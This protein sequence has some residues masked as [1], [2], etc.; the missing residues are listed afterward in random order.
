MAVKCS[1][2]GSC[3]VFMP[4]IDLWAVETLQ[5]ETEK[6]DSSPSS[7]PL[8]KSN[9]SCLTH[10]QVIGKEI[11]SC[12][13]QHKSVETEEFRVPSHAWSS[14]VEQVESICVSTSLMILILSRTSNCS[15]LIPLEHTVPRFSVLLGGNFNRDV[16]IN[17][18]AAELS[19]DL[20]QPVVQLIK[21]RNHGRTSSCKDPK[22]NGFFDI[23]IDTEHRSRDHAS[24]TGH[25]G[26]TQPPDDSFVKFPPPNNRTLKGRSN[27]ILAISTFGYQILRYPHFAELCWVT[28]KL[29]EGP[30]TDVSGPWKG[31][32]FNSCIIRPSDSV[33]K[34][35]VACDSSNIKSKEKSGLVRGLI[36]VGLIAY[37]EEYASLREVAL[38]VRR[39]L[40][41]L[42]GEINAKIQAGKDR[43]RYVRL[44][45]QV[46][47]LED[48]VNNWAH[49][50]QSLESDVQTKVLNPKVNVGCLDNTHTDTDN[51][52]RSNA[53][54]PS[55]SNRNSHESSG[56]E[57]N[58]Q[59]FATENVQR[60][61]FNNGYCDFG[62]LDTEGK[63]AHLEEGSALHIAHPDV[64][65]I[66]NLEGS[67]VA[68]QSVG[69]I[70]NEQNGTN[71]ESSELE[72]NA[73]LRP[74]EIERD[75]D[76]AVG[77]TH[78]G[79]MK[80]SNG[81]TQSV[82]LSEIGLGSSGQMLGTKLSDSR[83]YCDQINGLSEPDTKI[84]C[85]DDGKPDS[86]EHT[87]AINLPPSKTVSVSA[88]SE[89]ICMY[90][91][92]SECL[93]ILHA[94]MQKIFIHTLELNGCNWTA[95]DVHDVVA[96]L[97]VDLLSAVRNDYL[98]SSSS[99]SCSS[100]DESLTLENLGK[101]S[102]CP[103][104]N[105]C[106]CSQ[107]GNGLVAQVECNC[108]TQGERGTEKIDSSDEAVVRLICY[109]PMF[110]MAW[111][112][113]GSQGSFE[114]NCVAISYFGKGRTGFGIVI[115]IHDGFVMSS[116]SLFLDNWLEFLSATSITIL[117]RLKF[118]KW[119]GLHPFSVESDAASV[120]SM[121]NNGSHL[122]C[123]CGNI[124]IDTNSL[125]KD[126]DILS[127][128][129][130]KKGLCKAASVLSNQALF[131]MNDQTWWDDSPACVPREI[132]YDH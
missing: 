9:E 10:G 83:N 78:S 47:Y 29:K 12:L 73:D 84:A 122:N 17:L 60:L 105:T 8:T 119:C 20:I 48:V 112:F 36:A 54:K 101:L 62:H 14:F 75:A 66:N 56:V 1:S 11:D 34:V 127:I 32:P 5:H 61:S 23:C 35:A 6:S 124:I 30:C 3:L 89:I 81:F 65:L 90:R 26:G 126:L 59:G 55:V 130:E 123:S 86:S 88:D 115:R 128:S 42:V 2:V 50:L 92:C 129:L 70:I 4:R 67:T 57:G 25:E 18:S 69:K 96:S 72:R 22:T 113:Y 63:A 76:L 74:S 118:G 44:L 13:E 106:H 120:V 107:S 80:Y 97:S 77:V 71:L 40:E 68:D 109:F 87:A 64:S 100:F 111:C 24:A 19:R 85:N 94:L 121:I 99:S 37:R 91:C 15:H 110:S 104:I 108:H 117:K 131:W 52:N 46:A 82:I 33:E 132:C 49:A 95:E 21:Q 31:W 27:L 58:P 7:H 116:C 98:A 51:L 53:C 45:S 39:V 125:M 79:S 114:I 41:L 38:D 43:Y 93:C 103:G 16:V 102:G 28:S